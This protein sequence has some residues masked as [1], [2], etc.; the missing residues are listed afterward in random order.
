[1][2]RIKGVY[3]S[4]ACNLEDYYSS[5][6][7]KYADRVEM[8]LP[9]DVAD[10]SSIEFALAWCPAADAFEPYR[11]L[12]LVSSIAAG[13]DNILKCPSLPADAAVI[14]L[15]DPDQAK[16]MAAFA[17]WQ[18]VGAH[19]NMRRFQDQ[20]KNREWIRRDYVPA[21]E[22]RVTI[23]GFG[24]MGSALAESLVNLGYSVTVLA[25]TA[26]DD[27][28]PQ[29]RLVT[30]AEGKIEAVRNAD[31]VVN[32][33]PA[34]GDTENILD[35]SVFDAMAQ[36]ATLVNLGRGNHLVEDDLFAALD[37]GKLSAAALDVARQEPLPEDHPFW[38]H[39]AIA[40][41]PHIAAETGPATVV[42]L[43]MDD[44]D[45]FFGG[46]TPLGLVD[47]SRAY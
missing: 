28:L 33:L 16:D 18:V 17:L 10:P 36:G 41:T 12:R 38:S 13:V 40:L 22:F 15:R 24:M 2:A 8:A 27:T 20:Q 11:N 5:W 29:I 6:F 7:A 30:E 47:K 3:L 42:R 37:A 25:R 46:E 1:M 9:P 44:L 14:R 35:A 32:L 45:R 39:P 4:E 26:R 21:S 31:C 19:R 34:T 23:L 43:I